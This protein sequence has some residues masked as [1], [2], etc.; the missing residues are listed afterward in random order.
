MWDIPRLYI[1][2][3][4]NSV[5]L[6][7]IHPIAISILFH[8]YITKSSWNVNKIIKL[9]DN[10]WISNSMTITSNV[11]ENLQNERKIIKEEEEDIA[12]PDCENI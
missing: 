11:K 10:S 7:P 8:H 6:V 5:Q 9:I 12:T 1:S 4:S 3:C 2:A